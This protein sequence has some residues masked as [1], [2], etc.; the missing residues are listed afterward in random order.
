M[1]KK[2]AAAVSGGAV[3]MLVLSGCGGDGDDG[4]A[5][6]DAWAKKVCDK[7]EPELTKIKTTN[8]ELKR[9]A[10]QS[11]KPEEVQKT[12]S[13]AFQTLSDA[14]K[15][16]GGALTAAGEA[17]VTDGKA[18][19]DAV[20]KSYD[21]ISKSYIDLK[22]KIDALDAKDQSKFAEG[23]QQVA[24]GL[25]EVAANETASKQKLESTGL[26]V[27]YSQKG[28]QVSTPANG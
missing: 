3:L 24:G 23:L 7:W 12:D 4:K 6:A 28:C 11:N 20:V 22:T 25:T 21:Q 5:K 10:T 27:I 2:F 18:S 9:V 26:K 8:D 14:Y 17:P 16:M 1:N 13:A 19:Q 15:S